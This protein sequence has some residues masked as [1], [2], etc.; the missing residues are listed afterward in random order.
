VRPFR[1][2][3][4]APPQAFARFDGTPGAEHTDDKRVYRLDVK[5]RNED[6]GKGTLIL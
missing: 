2:L 4:T 1:S 6:A 5:R 3:T